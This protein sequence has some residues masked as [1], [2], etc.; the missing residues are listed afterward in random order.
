MHIDG[1]IKI[2]IPPLIVFDSSYNPNIH[3]TII[4]LADWWENLQNQWCYNKFKKDKT[5]GQL[6]PPRL[7]D[8][9][10]LE[11]DDPSMKSSTL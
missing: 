10:D 5:F 8:N 3:R 7:S 2:Y 4:A 11:L 6:Q 9:G 1:T